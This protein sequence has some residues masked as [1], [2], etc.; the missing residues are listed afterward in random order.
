MTVFH[1]S[2]S[3][4]TKSKTEPT[5]TIMI[6]K[7]STKMKSRK[8][9]RRIGGKNQTARTERNP[10]KVRPAINEK[11]IRKVRKIKDW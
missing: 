5:L 6:M 7:A 4:A 10:E 8:T 11:R 3:L 9:T 2:L 1:T